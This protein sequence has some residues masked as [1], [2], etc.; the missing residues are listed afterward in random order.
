MPKA[1]RQKP[2]IGPLTSCGMGVLSIIWPWRGE[3]GMGICW[4]LPVWRA[5][6]S[7]T[8]EQAQVL[9]ASLKG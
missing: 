7:L 2:T 1:K 5:P 8:L 9:H 4:H 3:R 6:A